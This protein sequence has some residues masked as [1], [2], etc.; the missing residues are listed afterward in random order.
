MLAVR[1][2]L[3]LAFLLT[4]ARMRGVAE[5]VAYALV[6]GTGIYPLVLLT[7]FVLLAAWAFAES[8]ADVRELF[9]GET[10]PV[11]KT[12]SN[13]RT[14]VGGAVKEWSSQGIVAENAEMEIKPF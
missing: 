10:V 2:G 11:W 8:V 12:E 3:N 5:S 1:E 9:A 13:W 14:S 4:N 6:G 7:Q